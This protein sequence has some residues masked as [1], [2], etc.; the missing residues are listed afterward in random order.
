MNNASFEG[1]RF[2]AGQSSAATE[3][4]LESITMLKFMIETGDM[5][6]VDEADAWLKTK[7]GE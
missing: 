2:I 4:Y 7:A 5:N 6:T 3:K 1:V